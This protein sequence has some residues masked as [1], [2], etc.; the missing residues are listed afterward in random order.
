[1]NT[2]LIIKSA[3]PEELSRDQSPRDNISIHTK[4]SVTSKKTIDNNLNEAEEL[5]TN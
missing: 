3:S 4:G 5:N 1:M 2:D